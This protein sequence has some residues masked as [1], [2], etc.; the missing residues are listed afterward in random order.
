MTNCK[1]LDCTLRD[2]GYINEFRFGEK[3]IKDIIHKLADAHT[4]IIECGFLESNA[5][6]KDE[7]LFGSVEAIEEYIVP[8]SPHSM[9]VAMVA[10]GDIGIDE[11]SHFDGKSIDGIR[12]TFHQSEIEEAFSYGKLLLEKGYQVFMQPVGT[13][14]YSEEELLC[15]IERVN[16]MKPFAFYMVDTLGTMLNENLVEMFEL[17]D[18]HLDKNIK[19][20]FHSHNNLQMSF[21]NAIELLKI[22]SEREIII[23]SSVFGM[24]R[25]AGNLCTELIMDYINKTIQ[26][27]YDI[28]PVLEIYDDHINKILLNYKWGYA[29]PY[30]IASTNNCHPNYATHL[31]NKRTITIKQI[32]SLL[33]T[34]DENKK[35]IY[36]KNYIEDIYLAFQKRM[37]DDSDVRKAYAKTLAGKNIVIIAPGSSIVRK[38]QEIKTFCKENSA[39][40][41]SVNFVPEGIDVDYLFVSN[42]KRI[43]KLDD[44]QKLK[45]VKS[46]LFTSN[47]M[48]QCNLGKVDMLNYSDYLNEDTVISD[49][50]GLMLINF[51]NKIGVRQVYLAGFDGFSKNRLDNYFDTAYANSAEYETLI[52]KTEAISRRLQAL[53][54]SMEI[55]FLTES[56]YE[57]HE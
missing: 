43:R 49:N 27:T 25:G 50:A 5:F 31:I 21:S 29:L 19:I 24:G 4:D 47:L 23:D 57:E 16:Q 38:M 42:R 51:L 37:V 54:N 33:S 28:V 15:L 44:V 8:K 11:I 30:F 14:S 2:G 9:Y 13:T 12:L 17:V 52:Y 36:D 10:Y 45:N 3:I 32:S 40:I 22:H 41:F 6:D 35:N 46:F 39:V 56:K 34:M 1:I 7:T 55:R 48:E 26:S 18:E 53:S 20:G